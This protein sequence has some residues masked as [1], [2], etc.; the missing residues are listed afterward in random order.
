MRSQRH[1]QVILYTLFT[2]L[3]NRNKYS[4]LIFET[5]ANGNRNLIQ[6]NLGFLD[7]GTKVYGL[8]SY[9]YKGTSDTN[10]VHIYD[11]TMCIAQASNRL[12]KN[13][14]CTDSDSTVADSVMTAG[15]FFETTLNSHTVS[16][17]YNTSISINYGNIVELLVGAKFN[18]DAIRNG[19]QYIFYIGEFMFIIAKDSNDKIVIQCGVLT[20]SIIALFG[21]LWIYILADRFEAWV[22]ALEQ[23]I[24]SQTVFTKDIT[25]NVSSYSSAY[26]Y[27]C[28]VKYNGNLNIQAE[29]R[30]GSAY[31]SPI[32]CGSIMKSDGTVPVKSLVP[33]YSRF[34]QGKGN[35]LASPWAAS[36][37]SSTAVTDFSIA[38][39]GGGGS[40]ALPLPTNVFV[41]CLR[42]PTDSNGHW[43]GEI[44]SDQ[45]TYSESSTTGSNSGSSSG[46]GSGG[47]CITEDTAIMTSLDNE[48]R[49][50]KD[51]KKGDIIVGATEEGLKEF[52]VTSK[53]KAKNLNNAYSIAFRSGASLD[54]TDNHPVLT[55]DGY[56]TISGDT[57]PKLSVGDRVVSI[58][59]ADDIVD[60][61]LINETIDTVYNFYTEAD[62][63][64]ANGV[65]VACED[66]SFDDM[67]TPDEDGVLEKNLRQ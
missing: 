67:Y 1:L 35:Y 4:K 40:T 44:V 24:V 38:Y 28:F 9:Q 10:P 29:F 2:N 7:I 26:M 39:F 22:E 16:E 54:I 64:I 21:M 18:W 36:D 5:D 42:I 48:F 15:R 37:D 27:L 66:N 46:G 65:V 53:Y 20:A 41:N 25:S 6:T 13:V 57:L 60:I 32:Y 61:S 8:P 3:M 31:S 59:D 52:T 14:K 50:A 55:L 56:K 58:G 43:T 30:N 51:I 34:I 23:Q 12:T 19:S 45:Y 11:N 63:F 49:L 47:G 17:I 62:N 33:A